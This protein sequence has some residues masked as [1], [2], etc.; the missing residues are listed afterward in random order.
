M[1]WFG[2]TSL[3]RRSVVYVAP[4]DQEDCHD[5]NREDDADGAENRASPDDADEDGKWAQS[6]AAAQDLGREIEALQTLKEDPNAE[7]CQQISERATGKKRNSQRQ[8]HSE[9]AAEYG[10]QIQQPAERT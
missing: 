10:N 8:D 1:S 2:N 7:R 5:G 9:R 6:G 3:A 4:D